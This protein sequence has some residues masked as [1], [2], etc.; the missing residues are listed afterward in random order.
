V[1]LAE[2]RVL[3]P[4]GGA[5]QATGA[6]APDWG[7]VLVVRRGYRSRSG[8]IHYALVALAAIAFLLQLHN[9]KLLGWRF[10]SRKRFGE[11][12]A[13]SGSTGRYCRVSIGPTRRGVAEKV[14]ETW[15]SGASPSLAEGG[16][17]GPTGSRGGFE[18]TRS[19]RQ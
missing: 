19:R 13:S 4:C 7:A 10:W 8:R 3:H 2:V 12:G 9:W 6:A 15:I 11:A 17:Q 5:A 18:R 1:R 16:V 14:P